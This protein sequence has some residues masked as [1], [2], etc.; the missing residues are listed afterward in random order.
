MF[1][2]YSVAE[3]HGECFDC[4]FPAL[5]GSIDVLLVVP[6]MCVNSINFIFCYSKLAMWSCPYVYRVI[7]LHDTKNTE[8]MTHDSYKLPATHTPRF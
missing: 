8:N 1:Q 3:F 5:F 7:P 6:A 4:V 2:I